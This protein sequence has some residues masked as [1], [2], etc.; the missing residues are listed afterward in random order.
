MPLEPA[1]TGDEGA[2]VAVPL[3]EPAIA[4]AEEKA[5]PIAPIPIGPDAGAVKC[6][7]LAPWPPPRA[8]E[9]PARRTSAE[10]FASVE[11]PTITAPT[12][13]PTMLAHAAKAIA[14]ADRLR[15]AT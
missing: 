4:G 3:P 12:S 1:V 7:T 10:N 6:D 11:T 13:A 5:R 9:A 2:I 8:N 15:A 14:E